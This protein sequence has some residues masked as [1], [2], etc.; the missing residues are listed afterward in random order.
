MRKLIL[1]STLF[2]SLGQFTFGQTSH[3]KI[4]QL[5]IATPKI[6]VPNPA[7]DILIP[8]HSTGFQGDGEDRRELFE[9]KNKLTQTLEKFVAFNPNADALYVGSL[10]QGKSLVDGV[11][12]PIKTNRT[13]LTITVTDLI[14]SNP[15][16]SF[17]KKV[18]VPSLASV[19]DAV[20]KILSQNLTVEQ[21]AKVTYTQTTMNSV[22]EAFLKLGASYKWMTGSVKGS[23]QQ[24]K[25]N[26]KSRFMVR[27]VQSYYTVAC[28]AP[29]NPASFI[30]TTAKITDI[31]NYIGKEN[32]PTYISSITYGRELWMMIES[33]YDEE[34][35]KATLDATFNGG[36]GSGELNLSAEQRKM[37]SES[38]IQILALGGGGTPIIKLLT[39][40]KVSQLKEY[41]TAGANYS[42]K[43]PGSIISYNVRYLK[44]NDIAKV[45]SFTDY[46]INTNANAAIKSIQKLNFT[47]LVGND[48]KDDDNHVSIQFI[49]LPKNIVLYQDNDIRPRQPDDND[50]TWHDDKPYNAI[51]NSIL[52]SKIYQNDPTAKQIKVVVSKTGGAHWHFGFDFSVTLN[53]GT[54]LPMGK[55]GSNDY[56][57]GDNYNSES[58]TYNIP[59]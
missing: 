15:A 32:P 26:T 42:K 40:D 57:F 33:S 7:D 20:S 11:L 10:I 47:F 13:P 51:L 29:S 24:S 43:S 46:T 27:F 21:P 23:F 1:F 14:N 54:V 18:N 19:T 44:D 53:D 49:V 30:A 36:F 34:R 12:S 9:Q 58:W 55:R 48:D 35:M 22:E 8:R 4:K 59:W 6:N 3:E 31:K 16:L 52:N 2:L 37:M 25:I 41:L 50:P 5:I 56:N 38:S 39:G 45:S 28:D 17:S